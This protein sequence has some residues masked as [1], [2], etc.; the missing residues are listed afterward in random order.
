MRTS[1]TSRSRSRATSAASS[2]RAGRWR[3]PDPTRRDR[4]GRDPRRRMGARDRRHA[5]ARAPRYGTVARLGYD[6][7]RQLHD[8]PLALDKAEHAHDRVL[9]VG[10]ATAPGEPWTDFCLREAD[11]AVA[12][13]HG[14]P[15]FGWLEQ[16][17][18]LKGCELVVTAG[19]VTE[20][21]I[22][23]L[24][25]REVQVVPG[26]RPG[27]ERALE[28]D[29]AAARGALDRACAVGRRRARL[30]PP[31]R[32]RRAAGGRASR[33]TATRA[34]AWARSVG[35]RRHGRHD[36]RPARDL[37]RCFVRQNPSRDYTLPA[38]SLI[39][40]AR[41]R[42]LLG[43]VFG[44]R[45]IGSSRTA[46]S[47]SQ[48]T[49]SPASSSSCAPARRRGRSTRAS[50]SPASTRRWRPATAACSSTAA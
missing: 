8:F 14:A 16:R 28:R 42:K 13:T 3:R 25:P 30:R 45:R 7:D 9:L 18:A 4:R 35:D 1:P 24:Q 19:E 27:C 17:T 49:C 43:E 10:A 47:A 20:G 6:A 37:P 32:A 44:D 34:R 46:S 40:G 29:R 2:Q 41:T 5:R 33:S 12:V 50:P 21:V 26:G 22:E 31:R 11:A 39:R 15:A 23:A 36:R 38:Y 48:P